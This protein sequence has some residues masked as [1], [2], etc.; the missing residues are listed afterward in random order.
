[1]HENARL[2]PPDRRRL[3][4]MVEHRRVKCHKGQAGLSDHQSRPGRLRRTAPPEVV[5]RIEAL[6]RQ[7]LT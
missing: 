7:W 4:L 5:E 2:T 6:C 3:L 1:M